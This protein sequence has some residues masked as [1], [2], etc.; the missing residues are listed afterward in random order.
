MVNFIAIFFSVFI[1]WEIENIVLSSKLF[2]SLSISFSVNVSNA[3][4]ASSNKSI[5]GSCN[6][7]RAIP[8]LC[9]SPP[10]RFVPFSFRLW[11]MPS[12]N[13]LVRGKK[14]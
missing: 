4:V 2:I 1:L 12:L 7:A 9:I 10:E 14:I 13:L 6:K 8:I 11:S 5:F 3:L